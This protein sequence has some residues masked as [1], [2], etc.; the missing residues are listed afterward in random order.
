MTKTDTSDVQTIRP[1]R[2]DHKWA[3]AISSE[4]TN[5]VFCAAAHPASGVRQLDRC[6]TPDT[7]G[8]CADWLAEQFRGIK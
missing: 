5:P 4:H 6:A 3:V 7:F 8:R 2:Y 1:R